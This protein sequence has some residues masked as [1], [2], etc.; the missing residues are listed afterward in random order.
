MAEL[1][2]VESRGTH[3]LEALDLLLTPYLDL[4]L[5]HSKPTEDLLISSLFFIDRGAVL[6]ISYLE[7]HEM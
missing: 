5:L 2:S 6:V 3:H 4:K 7:S 1:W